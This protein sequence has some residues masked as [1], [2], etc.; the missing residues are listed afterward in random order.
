MKFCFNWLSKLEIKSKHLKDSQTEVERLK[1]K[2]KFEQAKSARRIEKNA[3][4]LEEK[5]VE[6]ETLKT[7]NNE[8]IALLGILNIPFTFFVF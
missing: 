1:N 6:M 3:K 8:L 2:L 7:Q 5:N 4:L